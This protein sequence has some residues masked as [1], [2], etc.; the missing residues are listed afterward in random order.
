[1][2]DDVTTAADIE[3]IVEDIRPDA[4]FTVELEGIWFSGVN[5][6]VGILAKRVAAKLRE[7]GIDVQ[8]RD[9][10]HGG[11]LLHVPDAKPQSREA[12]PDGGEA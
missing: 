12:T 11:V 3:A 10:L 5:A 4:V 6:N 2:S 8:G 7:A 9:D 1:M